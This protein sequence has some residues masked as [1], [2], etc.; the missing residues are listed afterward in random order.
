MNE[1][2]TIDKVTPQQR[3]STQQPVWRPAMTPLVVALCLTAC[4]SPPEPPLI[5]PPLI[6]KAGR[7]LED[8]L[9][10][11]STDS[12]AGKTTMVADTP[13]IP[14]VGRSSTVKAGATAE[15]KGPATTTLMFDQLPLPNFIQVV[16]GS[17]L[18]KNFSVDPAVGTRADLVTLRTGAPQ[19]MDE[20]LNT[21]TM[22]LKSYG[23][24]VTEMGG[25]YRIAP[26]NN[27]SAYSPELRRGRA[28]PEVPLPLRPVFN[29]VEMGAVRAADVSVWLKAMFGARLNIQ[30]DSNRNAL[31]ISGQ[32][33]DI[34]AALEA[35]QVLDQPLMRG[36]SSRLLTPNSMGAEELSRR[37]T[38]LLAAEGYFAG[39]ATANLPVSFV[40]IP[41]SNSLVVFAVDPAVLDHVIAWA[42]KL[43]ALGNDTR[44]SGRFFSYAVKYADAQSLAKTMQDLMSNSG[45]TTQSSTVLAPGMR[46]I[47]D[48]PVV[49]PPG[50]IVVNAATNTLIFTSTAEEYTE[51][52]AILKEIDQPAK[53][54][55]IE[56]TVAEVR[57]TDKNQLGVEWG[58]PASTI[59]GRVVT[60]GT[61]G[62]LGQGTGGFT[63]NFLNNAGVVRAN[64]NALASTNRANI[65]STPR[66]MAR[67]G[68]TATI[69]VGQEVPII[70]SQQSAATIAVG[71]ATGILQTIQYRNT[72]VILKVKPVIFAG[73]RIEL[74]VSQEVSSA[75]E[76]KTGVTSSPTISSRKLDTKLSI[77]DGA[78]VLLGGLMSR[79]EGKGDTGIPFLK[80]IPLAGQLFR[81][82][83]ASNDKTELIVLITPYVIDDDLVAE[84]VTQ[85]FRNQLGGWAQPGSGPAP[86]ASTPVVP[87][88]S[89]PALPISLGNKPLVEDG[90]IKP[91][92]AKP[93]EAAERSANEP[94]LPRTETGAA[95]LPPL[96]VG[97]LAPKM[98][99]LPQLPPGQIITDPQLLEELR[100]ANMA[101][102]KLAPQNAV[103][104]EKKP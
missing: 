66:V 12:R 6:T 82:N 101:R 102:K 67:N 93:V 79:T 69:Q 10:P 91:S 62:G 86:V 92:D 46:V 35:I 83:T 81:T 88:S 32:A 55:L 44:K 53:S 64:L 103:P 48:A 65:L 90:S 4:A 18:K 3:G 80:D 43:D 71:A 39:N 20:V 15:P 14:P 17:I 33:V 94:K 84:Q 29:L 61:L 40:P 45:T 89:R 95:E 13:Q 38:E 104:P 51:L 85:A 54:A 60:G 16:F 47:G 73:N 41:A 11:L 99:V 7:Y 27:A 70:T 77:R 59:D 100:K 23:V 34:T 9:L 42:K 75:A 22:L 21:A 97:D 24:S 25:F 49:R 96:P 58:L 1:N 76:T 63:L 57:V 26:D 87:Q 50:R 8:G 74:D 98:P 36:R 30:D 68:E 56:V 19:T 5:G 52:L 78:T 31:L 2:T 37:L 72:G 28:Q